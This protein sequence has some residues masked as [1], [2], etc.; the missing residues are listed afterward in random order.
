MRHATH[1]VDTCLSYGGAPPEKGEVMSRFAILLCLVASCGFFPQVNPAA[2]PCEQL[3]QLALPN[4][5]ITSAQTIAAGA[6]SP[7]PAGS[8]WLIGDPS[9]YQQLPAFCRV[10]ADDK[11]TPDSDIK[12]EVWMPASGWN[13][14]FRGQGNGG[15]GGEMD[16]RALA[17][18]VLQGY[19]SAA[20]DTRHAASGTDAT[21][22]LGHPEKIIDYAHRAIHEMTSLSKATVKAFYGD[23]PKHSYFA[24]CSNGGR[25]TLMEAPRSAPDVDV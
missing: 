25:P 19:A 20:T 12:I 10:M 2:Q 21:W 13:S 24:S 18:A 7:P 5:K 6:F 11:P 8:P 3:A 17:V 15:F 23:A 4:T 1:S 14:K 16:Y 22:A 9:F